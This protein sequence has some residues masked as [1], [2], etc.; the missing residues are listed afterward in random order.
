MHASR[1]ALQRRSDGMRSLPLVRFALGLALLACEPPG[2]RPEPEFAQQHEAPPDHSDQRVRGAC[3]EKVKATLAQ[4]RTR[5]R[6]ELDTAEERLR[7]AQGLGDPATILQAM[8]D[9]DAA[10]ADLADTTA[11]D[12][13]KRLYGEC[14]RRGFAANDKVREQRYEADQER[15][16]KQAAA[17]DEKSRAKRR[18]VFGAIGATAQ[19]VAAAREPRASAPAPTPVS[20]CQACIQQWC[21]IQCNGIGDDCASCQTQFC[22]LQC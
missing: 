15:K 17:E 14:T 20:R 7:V 2:A 9:R 22:D 6:R 5:Q 19:G 12:A 8:K 21:S 13:P 4:R 3:Y 10:A 1:C 16:K 18:A 11:T